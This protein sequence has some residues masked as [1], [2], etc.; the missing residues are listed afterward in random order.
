MSHSHHQVSG[1]V[2]SFSR[3]QSFSFHGDLDNWYPLFSFIL[4][5]CTIW[6]S[7]LTAD[8]EIRIWPI[9]TCRRGFDDQSQMPKEVLINHNWWNRFWPITTS[10]QIM[11]N[12]NW[13]KYFRP[14]IF[15]KSP[16][17][18]FLHSF[19]YKA[20]IRRIAWLLFW[21]V[22]SWKSYEIYKVRRARIYNINRSMNW[23]RFQQLT[24]SATLAGEKP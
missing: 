8:D 21:L 20:S 9:I 5:S 23:D 7:R 15:W 19:W 11:F 10:W 2:F 3:S 16:H 6:V 14:I 18:P 13:W 1:D 22:T 24:F 4:E 12:H 17:Q